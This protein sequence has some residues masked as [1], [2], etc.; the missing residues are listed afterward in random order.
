LPPCV[1]V[2]TVFHAQASLSGP[3]GNFNSSL[4]KAFG[5]RCIF[6][7]TPG[8]NMAHGAP[9]RPWRFRLGLALAVL[10]AALAPASRAVPD[11]PAWQGYFSP[12]SRPPKAVV[13]ALDRAESPRPGPADHLPSAATR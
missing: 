9:A 12:N 4:R 10:A 8:T 7:D 2:P 3:P 5:D 11:E 6:W 1:P 13:G